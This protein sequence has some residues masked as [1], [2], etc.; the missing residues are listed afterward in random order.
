MKEDAS[1]HDVLEKAKHIYRYTTVPTTRAAIDEKITPFLNGLRNLES[2]DK[3]QEW[4][5]FLA[6]F[7]RQF[8]QPAGGPS[9]VRPNRG[10]KMGYPQSSPQ[11]LELWGGS[12]SRSRQRTRTR[13]RVH[14]RRCRRR[15][16]RGRGRGRRR[17]R[18]RRAAPRRSCRR[19]PVGAA[20][21]RTLKSHTRVPKQSTG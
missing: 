10:K 20:L 3:K 19:R 17:D 16:R 13:R 21:R 2:R 18:R 5:D 1:T 4:E 8:G 12:L 7:P 6:K 14:T 15:R 9:S 11:K